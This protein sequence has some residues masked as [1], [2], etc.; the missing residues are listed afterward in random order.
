[1]VNRTFA[2]F[3]GISFLAL[4]SLPAPAYAD[5]QM[6][7]RLLSPQEASGLPH[8]RGS[9]GLD[10]ERAQQITDSGMTFELIRVKQV[11]PHSA[12]AQAGFHRGDQIIAVDGQVFPNLATFANYVGSVP[13]GNRITVDYIP[14]GGGPGQAQRIAVTVGSPGGAAQ[15][16]RD[17]QGNEPASTGMSTRT[18]IGIGAAALL[19][20]YALGCFSRSHPNGAAT[21]TQ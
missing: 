2:A 8:N 16:A 15:T 17:Q 6:G 13:P 14:A 4:Q 5:N 1:M 11:R 7:Y 9:L 10:V 12:G 19:G 3:V 21:N 20:C 18:K